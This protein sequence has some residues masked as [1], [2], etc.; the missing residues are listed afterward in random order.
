MQAPLPNERIRY[1]VEVANCL[2]ARRPFG[3]L[4]F[5]ASYKRK[6]RQF[7]RNPEVSFQHL[8]YCV[9]QDNCFCQVTI[10]KHVNKAISFWIRTLDGTAVSVSDY[11][12]MEELVTMEIDEEVRKIQIR[13]L[14]DKI[15][16]PDEDFF[17]ELLDAETK[18]RLEGD[19]TKTRVVITEKTSVNGKLGFTNRSVKVR[20]SDKSVTLFME[21]RDGPLDEF[22]CIV[23]TSSDKSKNAFAS[24]SGDI[25]KANVDYRA[26]NQAVYFPENVALIPLEIELV[27]NDHHQEIDAPR[28]F[29]V[30]LSMETP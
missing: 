29:V 20:H 21:R 3:V 14:D 23:R 6:G 5:D 8:E 18:E 12:E 19:D 10:V 28:A 4:N 27:E 2:E 9:S 7:I 24:Y 13:V 22:T 11:F 15:V 1:R 17:I 16:E 26:V 30:E 25:A